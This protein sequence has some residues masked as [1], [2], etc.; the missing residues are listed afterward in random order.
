MLRYGLCDNVHDARLELTKLEQ[1]AL[2]TTQIVHADDKQRADMRGRKPE[3]GKLC[4]RKGRFTKAFQPEDAAMGSF[5]EMLLH[6]NSNAPAIKAWANACEREMKHFWISN[7][8][9]NNVRW[10]KASDGLP[11][12]VVMHWRVF[13]HL[14][15]KFPLPLFEG[16]IAAVIETLAKPENNKEDVL[17]R[18]QDSSHYDDV[19]SVVLL[20]MAHTEMKQ[21]AQQSI[22]KY[23]WN[24]D[25][26]GGANV[27]TSRREALLEDAL[28]ASSESLY[29]LLMPIAEGELRS[30][31]A[32]QQFQADLM[33]IL[34]WTR[35]AAM[36]F[37]REGAG[38]GQ[39][40]SV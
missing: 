27:W 19:V 12:P 7:V 25:K 14:T 10:L 31:S 15:A 17:R 35:S 20:N 34:G 32:S 18:V 3:P 11:D 16:P 24:A 39:G 5:Q 21:Q 13:E 40:R 1:L 8:P 26:V 23:I 38:L 33:Q 30:E 29:K 9:Y 36:R 4:R 37:A 22:E 2:Q 28:N 6:A